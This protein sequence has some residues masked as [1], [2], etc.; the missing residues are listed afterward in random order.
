MQRFATAH[1]GSPHRISERPSKVF[2]LRCFL[3]SALLLPVLASAAHAQAREEVRASH[4]LVESKEVADA[5]HKEIVAAGGDKKAFTNAAR[6]HS[7]DVTTKLLGGDVGWFGPASGFE[8]AFTATAFKLQVGEMSAPVQTPF[9][10]H[11]IFSADRREKGGVVINTPERKSQAPGHEGHDHGDHEGHDH[12]DH[13]GHDHGD[14]PHPATPGPRAENS[15]VPHGTPTPGVT[16]VPVPVEARRSQR[17]EQALQLTIE[18]VKSSRSY[19][20]RQSFRPEEA[21]E[22]NLILK[23]SGQ[24]EQKFFARELI[25]L[26]LKVMNQGEFQPLPGDFSSLAEPESFFAT[27]KP[28]EIMG[29]EA[30]LND[31]WKNLS[32]RRYTVGWDLNT[33]ITNLEGR[34]PKVK[35]LPDYAPLA[36]AM[37]QRFPLMKDVVHRDV[38]PHILQQRSRDLAISVFEERRPGKKYYVQMK[39]VGETQPVVIALS[40]EQPAAAKHFADLVLEGFYDNLDFFDIQKGD[41]L[42]GGSPTRNAGGAPAMQ[43]PQIRNDAKLDHKRGTVSFLSRNVRSK[44]PVRGGEVGSIF[45]VCLKPHPEWNDEHVPFGEVVAGLEILEKKEQSPVAFKEVTLLSE[46]QYTGAVAEIAAN[47]PPVLGNPE[48][49]L[50]TSKGSIT[51]ELF[52]DAARNTTANFVSLATSGFFSKDSTGTGKQKFFL[53]KDEAGNS[54]FA[55]TGSPT[56]DLEGGPGYSIPSETSPKKHIR[57]AL[58]MVVAYDE[59]AKK[60]V[61]DTAG[62]QFFICL[63]DIPY[64]DYEKN[65]TVFGQVKEGLDV[66]AKLQEGD[67]LDSV[68]I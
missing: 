47:P 13:E 8:Q 45:V 42:L 16:G 51:V 23:N 19:P 39:L 56:N 14:A 41:F 54:L 57:G 2:L 5:I 33:F 32:T 50:K 38:S 58:S 15:L 55:Q 66:L 31:Y 27:L 22:V 11:I 4:I 49:V 59:G 12:G 35:D 67:T 64:Y 7:K 68:E 20:Q 48:A 36:G 34:F 24:K 29:I 62:S 1:S 63:R 52:E 25:P 17:G 60:Y 26:G 30:S 28:Y 37:R 53:T 40:P 18:T 21:V 44:A 61:P 10:W 46:E 9:G 65:F 43:L 6:K 3:G